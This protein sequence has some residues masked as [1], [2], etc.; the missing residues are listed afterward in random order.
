VAGQAGFRL[1]R[2]G[3][4][5]CPCHPRSGTLRVLIPAF[6]LIVRFPIG[7]LVLA[8]H[9]ACFFP[10]PPYLSEDCCFRRLADGDSSEMLSS[11]EFEYDAFDAIGESFHRMAERCERP[12]QGGEFLVKISSQCNGDVSVSLRSATNS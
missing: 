2:H 3:F 6:F 7:R 4:F 8:T 10:D 11:L 9:S 12:E 5:D 1:T